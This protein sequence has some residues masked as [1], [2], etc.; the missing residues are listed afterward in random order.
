MTRVW[1]NYDG[2]GISSSVEWPW[3]LPVKGETVLLDRR[4]AVVDSVE[5]DL[6]PSGEPMATLY[7]MS[8][9]S[10]EQQEAQP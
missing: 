5:F 8:V 9:S 6:P 1:L 7:L 4:S 10:D 3:R 2:K